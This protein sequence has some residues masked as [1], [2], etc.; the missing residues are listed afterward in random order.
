M[1]LVTTLAERPDLADAL[2]AAPEVVREADGA[3]SAVVDVFLTWRAPPGGDAMADELAQELGAAALPPLV[4]RVAVSVAGVGEPAEDQLHLPPRRGRLRRGASR[5]RPAP[6]DRAPA[7]PL[8][9]RRTSRSAACRPPEDTYLFH[10]TA[11]ETPAD[12][13]LVA[14]AEVRDLTPVRD[15][16]GA[17]DRAARGRAQA[18]RRASRASAGPRPAARSAGASSAN[19]VFLYVWPTVD[20]PLRGADRGRAAARAHDR[21]PRPRGGAALLQHPRRGRRAGPAR[22]P[23]A[24]RTSPAPG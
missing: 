21:G 24:S 13:R 12:E 4:R 14:L 18:R 22:R 15:A 9:A 8:A 11:R 7:P 19:H 23:C 10:C 16:D 2:S 1:R 3:D 6:D 5:A 20:L 17:L